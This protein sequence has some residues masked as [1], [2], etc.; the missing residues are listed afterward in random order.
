MRDETTSPVA[1]ELNAIASLA[2]LRVQRGYASGK[3]P[4][5]AGTPI[6][7]LVNGE[8]VIAEETDCYDMAAVLESFPPC[9]RQARAW[10]T[11]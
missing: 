8:A 6:Y 5:E 3:F 11:L 1:E 2:G 10:A 7:K 9:A 4:I